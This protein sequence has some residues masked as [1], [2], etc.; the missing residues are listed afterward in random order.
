MEF[1]E[2][3]RREGTS[4]FTLLK[5]LLGAFTIMMMMVVH[6]CFALKVYPIHELIV[7]VCGGRSYNLFFPQGSTCGRCLKVCK[8]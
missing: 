3:R 2:S 7:I 1:S 4:M 5:K 8:V 6:M